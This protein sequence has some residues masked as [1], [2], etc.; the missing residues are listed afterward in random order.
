M[1][2]N[3]LAALSITVL[4]LVSTVGLSGVTVAES[5]HHRLQDDPITESISNQETNETT[6]GTFTGTVTDEDGD[7]I[8]G[9]TI[10]SIGTFIVDVDA[11]GAFEID[12]APGEYN[13]TVATDN[14]S[15]HTDETVTI[16]ENETTRRNFTLN[17]SAIDEP[18]TGTL[19]GTITDEDGDPIS[20]SR[21]SSPA[22]F[23][24]NPND[25]GEFEIDLEPGE[26]NITAT[27]YEI[28]PSIDDT[29]TIEEG[30]TTRRNFTFNTSATSETPANETVK[31]S[32]NTDNETNDET[33]TDTDSGDENETSGDSV[34]GFGVTATLVAV[35][36]ACLVLRRS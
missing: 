22:T 4:V 25:D 36:G 9:A 33:E 2:K 5:D 14:S 20:K 21:V 23:V 6:H 24:V 13:V 1:N 18:P 26:Y 17:T 35:L 28:D 29:V 3:R 12:L 11:D 31:S 32:V 34:P 30:E 16:E 19:T 10:Y 27:A 15:L 7:P 8:P